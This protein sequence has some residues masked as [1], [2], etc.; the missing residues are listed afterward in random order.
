MVA[1]IVPCL[2]FFHRFGE[3]VG[4]P[5]RYAADYATVGEDQS[6]G[7]AGDAEM[8]LALVGE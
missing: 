6:A 2:V 1:G 3:Q 4:S 7:C 8:N 5:V